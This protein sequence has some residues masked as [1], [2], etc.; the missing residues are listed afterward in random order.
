[1]F[2]IF[3]TIHKCSYVKIQIYTFGSF[4]VFSIAIINKFQYVI[5][6]ILLQKFY[7]TTRY[8]LLY[9]V[10]MYVFFSVCVS[11]VCVCVHECH[12]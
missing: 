6:I 4:I 3:K 1:M 2:C 8:V 7:I 9:Y 12:C 11:C 10:F 5:I